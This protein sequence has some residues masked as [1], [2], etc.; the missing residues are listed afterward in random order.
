MRAKRG[1]IALYVII[2]IVVISA[3]ALVYMF[4]GGT[5]KPLLSSEEAQKL[6][7]SQIQPVRDKVTDCMEIVTRKTLNTM[8]RQG[9][10]IYPKAE[11]IEIPS[12]VMPDAP[13]ISY[14]L[15]KDSSGYHNTLPS[16]EEMKEEFVEFIMKNP[17][18]ESCINDFE[19]FKKLMDVEKKELSIDVDKIDFG[20][21]SGQ[22]VIPF[23]YP[24][25]LRRGNAT[26]LVDNYVIKIPINLYKI[27]ETSV[28]I[29]NKIT[30]NENIVVMLQDMAKEQEKELRKNPE[31]EKLFVFANSYSE[32]RTDVEEIA[33]STKTLFRIEYQ[34]KALEEPFNFYFLSG[35]I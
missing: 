26:T 34:N 19:E 28:T 18:F 7:N 2:A 8:G 29:L 25:E 21:K 12:S 13:V 14:A 30:S 32:L 5:F 9:G 15:Y 11:R 24:V 16:V 35:E 20:E 4:R 23:N 1:Q 27:H 10:Y 17:E 6:V 31:S 33:Y 22:I 3:I